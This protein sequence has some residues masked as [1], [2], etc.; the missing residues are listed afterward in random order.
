MFLIGLFVIATGV[1]FLLFNNG[2][3]PLEYK[4]IVFSWQMLLIVIGILSLFGHRKF[5]FGL[6]LIA[7]GGVFILPE[8]NIPIFAFLKGN[9]LALLLFLFGAIL[10]YNA[11]CG[12]KHCKHSFHGNHQDKMKRFAETHGCH[13]RY[14]HRYS[15]GN[16]SKHQSEPG[17]IE[18]NYVFGG[19]NER[20]DVPDFKGGE[21]NCVFGGMELDLSG[22]QLAEGEHVLEVNS[23][24][25]GVVLFI[26]I[27]WKIELRQNT[28]VFG[29]FV[30]NRP[31]PNFEIQENRLLILEVASVFGGGEIRCKNE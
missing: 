17:F 3:L 26:P 30:D 6:L 11:I 21:I 1:L 16:Y 28:H 19:A 9:T 7:I 23:V 12:R 13:R 14:Y 22:A 27:D 4:P 18:R 15:D 29:N 24:F 20:F 10:I 5:F 25:G 2:I 8:L 31:K